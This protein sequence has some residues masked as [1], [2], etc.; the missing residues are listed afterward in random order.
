MAK[1][2]KIEIV[3]SKII[4]RD[5]KTVAFRQ[6]N[7][8]KTGHGCICGVIPFVAQNTPVNLQDKDTTKREYS[9]HG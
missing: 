1:N 9:Y 4:S 5:K 2:I 8:D 6:L 7:Q 3:E